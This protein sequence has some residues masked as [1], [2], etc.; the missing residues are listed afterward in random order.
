MGTPV[1]SVPHEHVVATPLTLHEIVSN[2]PHLPGLEHSSPAVIV[3]VGV[4]VMDVV[5]VEVMAGRVVTVGVMP[6]QEQAEAYAASST[7][8][9]A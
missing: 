6:Q 1:T 5:V 2:V 8:T 7:H 4:T 3:V 9:Q